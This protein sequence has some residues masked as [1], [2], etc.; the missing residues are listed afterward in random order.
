MLTSNLFLFKYLY[1]L[2]GIYIFFLHSPHLFPND[3]IYFKRAIIMENYY[4]CYK[5]PPFPLGATDQQPH[6]KIP[7]KFKASF[8]IALTPLPFI[9]PN[10]F[11]YFRY[12]FN[13]LMCHN[14]EKLLLLCQK[15]HSSRWAPQTT[16]KPVCQPTTSIYNFK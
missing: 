9:H 11:I 8:C 1:F 4:F 15:S 6:K 16:G 3:F 13:Y 7:L 5:N 12:D 10:D 14:Y 2:L